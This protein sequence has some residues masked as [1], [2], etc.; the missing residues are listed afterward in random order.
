MK[1]FFAFLVTSDG[2][3]GAVCSG[4]HVHGHGHV[5]PSRVTEIPIAGLRRI[6]NAN[7]VSNLSFR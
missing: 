4:V 3:V 2:G 7:A 5:I 6:T 1:A